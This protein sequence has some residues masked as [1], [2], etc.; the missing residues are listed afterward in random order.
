MGSGLSRAG[1]SCLQISQLAGQKS[2]RLTN[3]D[4]PWAALQG[5]QGGGL[6]LTMPPSGLIVGEGHRARAVCDS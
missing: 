2:G 4:T 1:P 5:C 3:S 6:P